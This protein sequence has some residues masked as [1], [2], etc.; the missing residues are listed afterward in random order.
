M[1]NWIEL[2]KKRMR[3]LKLTQEKLA[4]RVGVTQGAVGLWLR[5]ERE[6]SL[7]RMNDVLI[8]LEVPMKM[9]PTLIAA[10]QPANYGLPESFRYPVSNWE[11]LAEVDDAAEPAE[12][13]HYK[14]PGKAYWL[15]VE[16]DAMNA[17]TGLSVPAGMLILVA[18][19]IEPQT[20]SLVIV[21][22]P[23]NPKAVF[24]QVVVEDGQRLLKP[25]NPNYPMMLFGHDCEVVGVA[26]EA[27]IRF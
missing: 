13:S 3:E 4:E 12:L 11:R 21:R 16:G 10:E 23:G 17:P 24:R 1:E 26:V 2:V 7:K 6:P 9:G 5:D 18:S 25:L 15:R 8:A 22:L 19:G 14:A 27:T 20:G